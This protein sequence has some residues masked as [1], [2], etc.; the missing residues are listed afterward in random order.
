MRSRTYSL[1]AGTPTQVIDW[2]TGRHISVAVESD[3][4]VD[5]SFGNTEQSTFGKIA[6]ISDNGFHS[7]HI[8][9]GSL[10]LNLATGTV[11]TVVIGRIQ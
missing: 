1:S 3:G 11:A 2:P 8:G 7:D 5:V 9:C 10:K 6:T 4:T